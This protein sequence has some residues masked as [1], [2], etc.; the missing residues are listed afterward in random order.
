MALSQDITVQDR[1]SYSQVLQ[2]EVRQEWAELPLSREAPSPGKRLPQSPLHTW[3]EW[4]AILQQVERVSL[5]FALALG[6]LLFI[7]TY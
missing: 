2:R 6:I 5:V 1:S 7:C 3:R 4:P